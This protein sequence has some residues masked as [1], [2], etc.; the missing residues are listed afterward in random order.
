MGFSETT[1]QN[2]LYKNK[3]IKSSNIKLEVKQSLNDSSLNPSF[4]SYLA[5]LIEGNGL[6]IIPKIERSL[7]DQ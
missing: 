2:L 3:L 4:C 1:R 6:I 7:K 5:G